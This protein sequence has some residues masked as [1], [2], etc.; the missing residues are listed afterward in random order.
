[1][2]TVRLLPIAPYTVVNLVAGASHIRLRDFVLGT[3]LGMAPGILAVTVFE[4][5]LEL[6]IREPGAKSFA[7]LAVLVAVIVIVALVVKK[8]IGNNQSAKM[9]S[10]QASDKNAQA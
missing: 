7:L 1:M 5:Q 10:V 6:A 9:D 4:H 8:R 3:I 2:L